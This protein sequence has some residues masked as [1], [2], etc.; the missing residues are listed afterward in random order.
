LKKTE[1]LKTKETSELDNCLVQKLKTEQEQ[2]TVIEKFGAYSSDFK[3][4]DKANIEFAFKNIEIQKILLTKKIIETQDQQKIKD[5]IDEQVKSVVARMNEFEVQLTQF[6]TANNSISDSNTGKKAEILS[7]N[8]KNIELDETLKPQFSECGLQIPEIEDTSLFL[9]QTGQYIKSYNDITKRHAEVDNS[10]QQSSIEIGNFNTQIKNKEDEIQGINAQLTTL[11]N[12]LA[13][14]NDNRN[15]ILP[16]EISTANKRNELQKAIESTRAIEKSVTTILNAL[17]D[18]QTG[19]VGEKKSIVK[20]QLE[21]AEQYKNLLNALSD[22]IERSI[23]NSRD[24]VAAAL[25]NEDVLTNYSLIK[26][27]V[28]ERTIALKTQ[29]EGFTTEHEKLESERKNEMTEEIARDKLS[30]LND[31]R[32]RWLHMSGVITEKFRKDSEIKSR[33]AKVVAEIKVQEIVCRKWTGLMSLLGGSQD[34]FNTY[35]QRLTLKNLID[36]ANLHLYKLNRRYSLLLNPQ[37][38]SGEEL[39]FRLVD[40]YQADDTRLT[41]TTSGGEKFLISL[42]L[43]LGLSDLAS[44]NVSIGSLFIDEGF[45]TLDNDT[46]ETVISTLE[47]LKAQGKTI[48]IISHVDSLKERIPVQIQVLKKSNG[49]SIVEMN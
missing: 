20:E 24:E 39:N 18:T 30:G 11:K 29:E 32:N 26:K 13:L 49:V 2:K 27:D 3:I 47:T 22:K 48:G 43:A 41:D 33:N 16:L 28:D 45:G 9:Q 37:Y 34:A 7:L 10:I 42:S 17:K 38:K 8:D 6:K 15:T 14:F 25:L 23:F 1:L 19:L 21:N 12:E 5:E 46:L 40:H 31:E 44:H 36:L 35:V 4:E